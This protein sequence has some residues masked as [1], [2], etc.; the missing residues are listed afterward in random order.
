MVVGV[1]KYNCGVEWWVRWYL[2]TTSICQPV[3]TN[4]GALPYTKNNKI[5][6]GKKREGKKR[7][8]ERE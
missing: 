5:V 7:G 3:F 1:S 2:N 4:V 6:E 8:R